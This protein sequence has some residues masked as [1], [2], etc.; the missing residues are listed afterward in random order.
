MVEIKLHKVNHD[1]QGA[2][3]EPDRAS[4][5]KKKIIKPDGDKPIID[6]DEPN[7]GVEAP[8]FD[9]TTESFEPTAIDEPMEEVDTEKVSNI[10][11]GDELAE[12]K[13]QLM[14]QVVDELKDDRTR[15]LEEAKFRREQEDEEHQRY[16]VKMK[17]SP[18]P[19]VDIIGWVR[20]DEGVKVELE[21]NDAFV[22]YLRA[23]GIKGTDDESLVQRWVTLLLR[24]MADG[25]E[26]R[27]GTDE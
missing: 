8:A 4:Q 15:K 9:T 11:S 14:A 27:F 25:M 2:E 13:R 5:L 17:N 12:I 21:W 7:Q 26:D 1:Q 23:N 3:A 22:D 10:L 24:D 6:N 19:W 18:D 16:I 20:T